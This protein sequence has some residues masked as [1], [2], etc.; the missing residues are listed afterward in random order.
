MALYAEA[1]RALGRWLGERSTLE[2]IA[3]AGG[4]AEL[5]ATQLASA[6]A[7]FNDRGFYK[8]AQIVP[9][10]EFYPAEEYHQRY[11]EKQGIG[12]SCHRPA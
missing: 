1:L 2:V 11:F 6:M 3:G 12:A 8:R 5:L 9:A 10:T 4:S 7:L